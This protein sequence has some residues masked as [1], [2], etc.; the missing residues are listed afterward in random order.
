[1]GKIN[2]SMLA[3][4]HLFVKGC[5]QAYKQ[6][7]GTDG[8]MKQLFVCTHNGYAHSRDAASGPHAPV[9]CHDASANQAVADIARAV[10]V[11]SCTPQMLLGCLVLC[12]RGEPTCCSCARAGSSPTLATCA[13]V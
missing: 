3:Y 8:G 9:T 12:T 5:R 7:F 2:G 4:V 11:P 13:G 10:Q 6:K 1:M